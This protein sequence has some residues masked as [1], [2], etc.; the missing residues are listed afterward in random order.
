LKDRDLVLHLRATLGTP[1]GN[2]FGGHLFEATILTDKEIL[3]CRTKNSTVKK[4]QIAVTELTE[5]RKD[6]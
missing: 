3:I 5:E 2:I 4:E 6:L 1:Y